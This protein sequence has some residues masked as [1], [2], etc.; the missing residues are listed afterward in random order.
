[1]LS[2]FTRLPYRTVVYTQN[3]FLVEQFNKI[4]YDML[5]MKLDWWLTT[6][7]EH[8]SQLILRFLCCKDNTVFVF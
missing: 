3:D 7:S 8:K 6:S 4:R 2:L 5:N 1:M